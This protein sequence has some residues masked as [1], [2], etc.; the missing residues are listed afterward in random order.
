M[1]FDRWRVSWLKGTKLQYRYY[2]T[3]YPAIKKHIQ[4]LT[5]GGIF[6]GALLC[7]KMKE[8]DSFVSVGGCDSLLGLTHRRE[9]LGKSRE[10][11][12]ELIARAKAEIC[13]NYDSLRSKEIYK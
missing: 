9:F 8:Y 4:N 12:N 11:W 7:F 10:Y 3:D 1:K 6:G 13:L 2:K 5:Q